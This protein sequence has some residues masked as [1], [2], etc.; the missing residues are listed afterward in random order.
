MKEE[1]ISCENSE[2]ESLN[3]EVLFMAIEETLSKIDEEVEVD[4]EQELISSLNKRKKLRKKKQGLK[5]LLQEEM[6]NDTEENTALEVTENIIE[7]LK[8]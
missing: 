7:D 6:N 8:V 1:N 2:G 3:D 5:V 4:L